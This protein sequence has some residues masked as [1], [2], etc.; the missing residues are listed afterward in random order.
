MPLEHNQLSTSVSQLG[1]NIAVIFR[2]LEQDVSHV[3]LWKLGQIGHP[4]TVLDSAHQGFW[5]T[6]YMLNLMKF[7]LRYLRLKTMDTISKIDC[8]STFYWLFRNQALSL[9]LN[10]SVNSSSTFFNNS[11]GILMMSRFQICSWSLNLLKNWLR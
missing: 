7:W 6:P 10:I 5:N 2:I 9:T 11:F 3:Y 1:I 4:K 8:S